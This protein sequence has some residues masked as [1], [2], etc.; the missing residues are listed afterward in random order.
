MRFADHFCL[1]NI[2]PITMGM[3]TNIVA[4]DPK[5]SMS[6]VRSC[7]KCSVSAVTPHRCAYCERTRV[8]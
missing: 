7:K 1:L 2:E 6:P 5:A 4:S 3:L 8:I